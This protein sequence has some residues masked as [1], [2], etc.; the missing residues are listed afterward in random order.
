LQEIQKVVMNK[1]YTH[2]EKPLY[3][4]GKRLFDLS[5]SACGLTI[6]APVFIGV[7]CAIKMEDGGSV[8]Y[9]Q[10]RMG[11]NF[12][13]FGVFKFRSMVENADKLGE[14]IT[15]GGDS[16]I[17]KTGKILRKTKLDELPQLINV[18][19]GQM[20]LVGP[21]PEVE[22]YTSICH[23]DYKNILKIKPGIT[24]YAAI[25]FI[26]EESILA[27]AEDLHRAYVEDV[28]PQKIK[29]YYKYLEKRSLTTDIS[30]IL[31][32]LAKIIIK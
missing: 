17:T 26:D 19:L 13:P 4:I 9:R 28:L 5:A 12:T 21:R 1:N 25:D 7:A 30:L 16:R 15:K 27:K 14:A 20:S 3:N 22:Q 10:Q 32:T 2:V 29:L 8:F 6:L 31:R 11:I 18:F 23:E 24:D